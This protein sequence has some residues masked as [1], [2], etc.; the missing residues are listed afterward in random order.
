[1]TIE[2]VEQILT[3]RGWQNTSDPRVPTST[4]VFQSEG[5]RIYAEQGVPANFSLRYKKRERLGFNIN[6]QI[7]AVKKTYTGD[8]F[9]RHHGNSSE[10]IFLKINESHAFD[11]SFRKRLLVSHT[12]PKE[13]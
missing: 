10:P 5:V 11:I 9:C 1:M 12:E 13:K 4:N 6:Q 8:H 7:V 2:T 3:F